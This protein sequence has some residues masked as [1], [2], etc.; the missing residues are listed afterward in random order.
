ERVGRGIAGEDVVPGVAGKI[1]AASTQ[2]G[3]VLDAAERGERDGDRHGRRDVVGQ[4]HRVVAFVGE[5]G[6][7]VADVVDDVGVVAIP[8]DH[9]VRARAAVGD[10]VAAVAGERVAQGIAGTVDVGGAEE[11]G[12]R[13]VG[14]RG[15]VDRGL[16]E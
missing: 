15:G 9:A 14:G 1:E 5:L 6:D 10:V 13:P 8:A 2:R 7:R 4:L 12:A 3:E 11:G 16:H